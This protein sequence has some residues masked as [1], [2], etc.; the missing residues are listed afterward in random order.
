MKTIL[1]T[2]LAA[3][4]IPRPTAAHNCN[5]IAMRRSRLA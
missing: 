3:Y 2:A 4:R 1:R 5:D